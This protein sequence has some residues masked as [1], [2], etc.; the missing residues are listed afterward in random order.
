MRLGHYDVEIWDQGLY[1]SSGWVTLQN[2][3]EVTYLNSITVTPNQGEQGQNLQVFISGDDINDFIQYS[4]TVNLSF[5]DCMNSSCSVF[6]TMLIIGNGIVRLDLMVSI[7][8]F[9]SHLI[10]H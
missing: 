8:I 9:K 2:G 7:Q 4:N 5:G 1:Q 10:N 3:F 6:Q